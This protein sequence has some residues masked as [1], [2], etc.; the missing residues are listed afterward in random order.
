MNAAATEP[1]IKPDLSPEAPSPETPDEVVGEAVI[2]LHGL[3][4]SGSSMRRLERRLQAEGYVVLNVDYPSRSAPVEELSG[5]TV[6][7]ALAS[8]E[9]AEVTRIHFVTHSLGGILVRHYFADRQEP[10]LGRVVMLGPPNQGSEVVDRIGDWLLF[11]WINGPAGSQLGTEDG[12]LPNR[13][14]PVEFELGIVAGN[15]SI[16]WINS[17]M[18]EG[19]DDGKVSV[20]RTQV[21]GMNDHLVLPVT[22]PFLMKNREVIRQTLWFLRHG[23]FDRGDEAEDGGSGAE[24]PVP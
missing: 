13:L 5:E 18:I 2:L 16:N 20:E 3:A 22:H 19:R 12:S 15:W 10:R 11:E 4:R 23:R 7:P 6:G 9:L 8:P 21:E 14:G 17:L 24:S 1:S